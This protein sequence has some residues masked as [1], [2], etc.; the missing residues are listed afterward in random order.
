M[1][2]CGGGHHLNC[3]FASIALFNLFLVRI[4]L[5]VA[6][7]G[8][9]RQFHCFQL[10]AQGFLMGLRYTKTTFIADTHPLL[11][12]KYYGTVYE[13]FCNAGLC[14]A[15]ENAIN[16]FPSYQIMVCFCRASQLPGALDLWSFPG[17]SS[18]QHFCSSRIF[19]V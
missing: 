12:N 10:F 6:L 15:I 19:E 3:S 11:M 1:R 8:K 9:L 4:F 16:A 7:M 18:L 2:S 13:E 17:R 14:D 5:L